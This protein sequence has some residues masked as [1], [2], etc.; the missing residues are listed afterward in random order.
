MNWNKTVWVKGQKFSEWIEIPLNERDNTTA[1]VYLITGS[2]LGLLLGLML[3]AI[4]S[5]IL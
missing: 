3:G 4:I 5:I 2:I 1:R